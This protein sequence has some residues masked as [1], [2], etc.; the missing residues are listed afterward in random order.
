MPM[1]D[2]YATE[3]TFGDKHSLAKDLA[4][5]V[6]PCQAALRGREIAVTRGPH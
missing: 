6:M 2:V 5:A 4:S 3:G 1:I